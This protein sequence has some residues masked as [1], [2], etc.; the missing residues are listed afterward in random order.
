MIG[1]DANSQHDSGL[2]GSHDQRR[3]RFANENLPGGERRD[4]QL[5]QRALLT[6]AGYRQRGDDH[7]SDGGDHGDQRRND[8]PFVIQIRV[9]PVTHHQFAVVRLRF[10]VHQLLLVFLN[11]LLQIIRCDLRAV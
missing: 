4:Q 2:K 5:I 3:H 9:I 6:F 7:H 8:K 1:P 10:A 11:D